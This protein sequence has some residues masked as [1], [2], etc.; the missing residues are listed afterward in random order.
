MLFDARSLVLAPCVLNNSLAGAIIIGAWAFHAMQPARKL[1]VRRT[2]SRKLWWRATWQCLSVVRQLLHV[3]SH[4][5]HAFTK[6][7]RPPI[8][9]D[10]PGHIEGSRRFYEPFAPFFPWI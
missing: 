1:G 4:I 2:D 10:D 8:A 6:D 3:D 9:V 5:E 7:R